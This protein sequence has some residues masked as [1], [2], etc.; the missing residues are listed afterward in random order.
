VVSKIEGGDWTSSVP[1]WCTFDMRISF[2]PGQSLESVRQ[3]VETAVREAARGDSFLANN[4]PEVVYHGFQAEPYIADGTDAIRGVLA[5]GHQL[6]FGEALKGIAGTATTDARFFGLYADIPALV[7][8]PD[9]E[10]YHGFDERVN[11]ESL[12]KVTQAIAL[13]VAEW[14]GLEKHAR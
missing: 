7:Y 10:D 2:Y 6:A 11:L 12:R 8:G 13:F 5:E 14:C 4:P 9:A 1:A 3:A